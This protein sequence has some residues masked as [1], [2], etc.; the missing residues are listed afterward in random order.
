MKSIKVKRVILYVLLILAGYLLQST[1]FSKMAIASVKPNLLLIVTA[2]AG[3]MHGSRSGMLVGFF[4][5]LLTDIMFGQILGFYAL[6]YM[7]LGYV[8]GMFHQ[9]YFKENFRIPS[10]LITG[11][12]FLYSM[13]VYIF[14]FMLRRNFNF[15]YYLWHIIL[16]ELIYTIIVALAV[17]PLILFLNNKLDAEEKRSAN[18]IG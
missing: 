8:N 13:A 16:P 4:S 5:G 7:V 10:V 9:M 12:E 14:L 1:A 15:L 11:S 6:L 3:F 17:Y 2:S 18:K